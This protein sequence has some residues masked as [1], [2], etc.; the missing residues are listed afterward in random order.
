LDFTSI[1]NGLRS[2][3]EA[4]ESATQLND[5]LALSNAASLAV[6]TFA[7]QVIILLLSTSI[8]LLVTTISRSICTYFNNNKR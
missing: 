2:E 3:E 4:Y 1:L 5:Y 6:G 8:K 7:Q